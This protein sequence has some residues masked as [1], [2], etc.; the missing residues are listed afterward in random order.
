[1][2]GKKNVPHLSFAGKAEDK[3]SKESRVPDWLQKAME[4]L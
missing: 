2:D 1:M 3:F 4:G